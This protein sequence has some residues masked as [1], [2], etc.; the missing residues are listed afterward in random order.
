MTMEPAVKVVLFLLCH[1]DRVEIK[2]KM[3]ALVS[4]VGQQ[5]MPVKKNKHNNCKRYP[6]FS[7][8]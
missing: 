2:V 8:K 4:I 6:G 1:L 7:K 5:D 3:T